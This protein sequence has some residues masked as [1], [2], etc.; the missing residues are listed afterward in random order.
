MHLEVSPCDS[1]AGGD[2]LLAGLWK[3]VHRAGGGGWAARRLASLQGQRFAGGW[4]R[5]HHCVI[6]R[7]LN[8]SAGQIPCA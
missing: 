8:S 6:G 4:H 1:F 7:L 2:L 3:I 5:S